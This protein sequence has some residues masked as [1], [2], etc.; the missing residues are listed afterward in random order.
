MI[1]EEL[2]RQFIN[3]KITIVE[4]KA[5]PARPLLDST[6]F[7]LLHAAIG[8]ATE[9]LELAQSRT[10]TN[11]MEEIEDFFWYLTYL[12]SV[13][14]IPTTFMADKLAEKIDINPNQIPIDILI[15][16]TEAFVSLVK[17]HIIYN[18][19]QDFDDQFVCL[20]NAF[21]RYITAIN[22]P[23]RDLIHNN[24]T[25]LTARYSGGFSS[26]ESLE[27]K[28]KQEEANTQEVE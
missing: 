18:T 13:L 14:D 25:K 23:I 16:E 28:D 26:Q 17:K 1:S 20:L 19:K 12:S 15:E 6:H 11:T 24:T 10:R 8:L 3:Y 21:R 9:I 22:Y 7:K 27:R 4:Y 2:Y 5:A